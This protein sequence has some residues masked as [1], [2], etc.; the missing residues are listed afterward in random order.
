MTTD[1]TQQV[2]YAG[3]RLYYFAKDAGAGQTNGQGVGGVWFV[4]DSAGR[5]VKTAAA[6]AAAKVT[7]AKSKLGHPGRR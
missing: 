6:A 3:L 7:V 1:G 5:L 2:T 4:V